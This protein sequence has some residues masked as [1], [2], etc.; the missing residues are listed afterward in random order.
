MLKCQRMA[1]LRTVKIVKSVLKMKNIWR[2][3][4]VWLVKTY[5]EGEP[6]G[7]LG[8]SA[9]RQP[10]TTSSSWL[11][12]KQAQSQML[13]E[14]GSFFTL[15]SLKLCHALTKLRI[16]PLWSEVSENLTNHF[17]NRFFEVW[18]LLRGICQRTV[19]LQKVSKTEYCHSGIR[20]VSCHQDA[21]LWTSSEG[22]VQ[23]L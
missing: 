21:A 1:L 20:S 22:L 7:R 19:I 5:S 16:R 4:F 14:F 10:S 3:Q 17:W 12:L 11:L 13:Q 2:I 6:Q 9:L 23:Y 8:W 18:V 15:M